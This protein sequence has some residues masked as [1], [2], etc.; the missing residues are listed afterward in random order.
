MN[1]EIHLSPR[2]KKRSN[3]YITYFIRGCDIEPIIIHVSTCKLIKRSNSRTFFITDYPKQLLSNIYNIQQKTISEMTKYAP[4]WFQNINN[5]DIQNMFKTMIQKNKGR[6]YIETTI[7]KISYDANMKY[8][9]NIKIY[10]V[11][12]TSNS[13]RLCAYAENIQE[14]YEQLPWKRTLLLTYNDIS[15]NHDCRENILESS[16]ECDEKDE[17]DEKDSDISIVEINVECA[18]DSEIVKLKPRELVIQDMYKNSS[19]KN[20]HSEFYS[21]NNQ[22]FPFHRICT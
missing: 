21:T 1:T 18:D 5:Q 17:K 6:Q 4:V 22:Q 15:E 8:S 11:I 20:T 19:I 2:L 10:G 14:I 13:F 7:R 3:E 9:F 12:I 16:N